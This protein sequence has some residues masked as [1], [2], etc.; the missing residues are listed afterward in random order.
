MPAIQKN[1]TTFSQRKGPTEP[2]FKPDVASEALADALI[3]LQKQWNWSGAKIGKVL[4]LPSRTINQWLKQRKVPLTH[5]RPSPEIEA[6]IHLI[7]INR[8]LGA[9]FAD[10]YHQNEWLITE[11]PD[12][13]MSPEEKMS[14]S[15]EGLIML[16]KYLDYVRGR[17][18]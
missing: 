4:H 17:G 7:A 1:H 18:A 6:V 8:S 11:H 9:M 5:A 12:L 2:G 3:Y 16:R 15:T 13:G 10:P 14:E